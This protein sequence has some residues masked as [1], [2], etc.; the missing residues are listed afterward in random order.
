MRPWLVEVEGAELRLA[1]GPVGFFANR[2]VLAN[3]KA[4]AIERAFAITIT[5]WRRRVS[6]VGGSTPRLIAGEVRQIGW[7]HYLTHRRQNRGHAFFMKE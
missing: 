7:I 3:S 1:N 2:F 4:A 5:G 6:N